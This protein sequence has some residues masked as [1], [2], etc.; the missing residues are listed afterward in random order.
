M[1]TKNY[2]EKSINKYIQSLQKDKEFI[3]LL[4]KVSNKQ[5]IKELK[6]FN[7]R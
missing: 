6:Q 5:L 1:N 3:K 7:A 4:K 2:R